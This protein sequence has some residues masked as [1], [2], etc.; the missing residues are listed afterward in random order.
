MPA[1]N[2]RVSALL[3][4]KQRR[5]VSQQALG[6]LRHA[7]L[8][9]GIW[10]TSD[11]LSPDRVYVWS[12][13][14]SAEPLATREYLQLVRRLASPSYSKIK[15]DAFRTLA[16]DPLFRRRVT[17][18]ALIRLLNAF[19]WRQVNQQSGLSY[20]QGMNVLAA[21]FLYASRSETQ[22]FQLFSTFIEKHCPL[23]VNPTLTGVHQGLKLVDICLRCVEKK[24]YLHLK[25]KKL[26]AELYAFPHVLTF[27]ACTKP[28]P[29]VMVLW[30]FLLAYGLHLNILCI[31]AQ[32]LLRRDEVLK[33]DR[34]DRYTFSANK[35]PCRSSAPFHH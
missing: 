33:S 7:I 21:P 29:E 19:V 32:I 9:D 11:G 15:N 6:D 35:A 14:L 20:V 23:Y 5:P 30:D 13:L 24:L 22:A 16:T 26:S 31:I 8:D 18:T 2:N 28:L 17:E 3:Q 34:Y 1:N 4:V 12:I 27:S 10:Q 25:A